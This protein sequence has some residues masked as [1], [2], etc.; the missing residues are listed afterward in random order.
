[1][2]EPTNESLVNDKPES[3]R[4]V[5][6][7]MITAGATANTTEGDS[8]ASR[9]SG[10]LCSHSHGE[11]IERERGGFDERRKIYLRSAQA[12]GWNN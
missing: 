12:L 3:D 2:P 6:S 4:E 8:W 10:L 1:M 7:S 9:E 11:S 5:A